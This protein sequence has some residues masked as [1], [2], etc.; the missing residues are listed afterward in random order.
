MKLDQIQGPRK[1]DAKTPQKGGGALSSRPGSPVGG[2]QSQCSTPIP[3]AGPAT[4]ARKLPPGKKRKLDPEVGKVWYTPSVNSPCPDSSLLNHTYSF[5]AYFCTEMLYLF[6][7]RYPSFR[8]CACYVSATT[9]IPVVG[10]GLFIRGVSELRTL[11]RTGMMATPCAY[12]AMTRSVS[13][14]K[15]LLTLNL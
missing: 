10:R 12:H 11:Y 7:Y 9:G 2:E 6:N 3:G 4:A 15:T 1:P 5:S 8:L 13:S 14:V